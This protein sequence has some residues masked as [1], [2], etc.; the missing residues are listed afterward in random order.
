[1]P[2]AEMNENI[3]CT[4]PQMYNEKMSENFKRR[5]GVTKVL[6]PLAIGRFRGMIEYFRHTNPALGVYNKNGHNWIYLKYPGNVDYLTVKQFLF[7]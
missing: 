3:G 4:Y 5:T 1:M 2:T 6:Y 7:S